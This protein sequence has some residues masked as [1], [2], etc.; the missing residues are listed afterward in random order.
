[1]SIRELN[2][3]KTLEQVQAKQISQIEGAKHLGLSKRQMIRVCKDFRRLGPASVCSKRRG[4]PSNRMIAEPVRLK[5]VEAIKHKYSDFGP[6]FA[7]EKLTQLHQ[8]LIGVESVRQIMI[9]EGLWKPRVRKQ[10]KNHQMRARRPCRGELVQ[11]DG[12]PHDWFEGRRDSCCLLVFIDDA[13]SEILGLRFVEREAMEGY[14]DLLREYI[15]RCGRPIALYTD[16]HATFQV[17][18][19]EAKSGTGE[20]Q[21]GRATRELGIKL[22]AA[23][24]PQAKGRVERANKTLQDRLVKELRLHDISD[25]DSANDYLPR[26]MKTHNEKFAVPAAN[27]FDAHQPGL[28]TEAELDLILSLQFERSLS[29]SLE[30]SYKSISYQVQ[31]DSPSYALRGAKIKVCERNGKVSLLYKGKELSYKIF[32]KHNRPT[33]AVSGKELNNCFDKSDIRYRPRENHPWKRY[34]PTKS[35]ACNLH[36]GDISTWDNR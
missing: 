23:H 25:I 13:T 7:H 3:L 26:F 1:M 10:I 18:A 8:V 27:P 6:T 5:V 36:T 29:K 32:D 30:L 12:S 33:E 9:T 20:T 21:F 17:N 4:K 34:Y 22:I 15:A 24:S 11:I 19:K 28:P 31:T 35:T 16:K 14:F 2:R